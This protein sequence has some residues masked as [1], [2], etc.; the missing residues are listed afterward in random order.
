MLAEVPTLAIEQVFIMNNTSVIHDEILAQRLGLIPLTGDKAFIRSL[1][2]F[3]RV[4][5][6]E[7]GGSKPYEGNAAVLR[8]QAECTWQQDGHQRQKDGERDPKKLYHNSSVYAH[9]LVFARSGQQVCGADAI[10]PTNPDILIAKMRPGQKIDMQMFAVKGVGADHAKYSPVATASYR[11]LPHIEITKPILGADAD[12]FA[13][14][15][16][17][18]VIAKS[19]VTAAEA[20]Q[21]G[22]GY[23]GHEGEVKAVVSDPMR[24][25][26]SRECLRHEEFKDK[27]KLGRVRDH[28]IFKVEST[29]QY[30]ADE[31]FLESVKILKEKCRRMVV[32]LDN[33]VGP[34]QERKMEGVQGQAEASAEDEPETD[35]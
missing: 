26:V 31:V 24:D 6:G 16:P 19:R 14:C 27:V 29:G 20:R 2:F 8:L 12:K 25:T 18:G 13:R 4:E 5:P 3:K 7:D 30:D 32:Q 17:R 35:G 23:E 10:R 1:R 11:L 21:A 15:F 22:S 34:P 33:L 28:F 9:Q